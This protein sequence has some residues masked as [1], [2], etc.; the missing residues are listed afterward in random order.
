MHCLV[1][2]YVIYHG[3]NYSIANSRQIFQNIFF[4]TS[5]G[6]PYKKEKKKFFMKNLPG[7]SNNQHTKSTSKNDRKE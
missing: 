2:A 7:A 5:W 3:V 1:Y 6:F 4:F